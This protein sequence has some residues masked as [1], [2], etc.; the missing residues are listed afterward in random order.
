MVNGSVKF[1]VFFPVSREFAGEKF[2]LDW[3]LRHRTHCLGSVAWDEREVAA[4]YRDE[5][6]GRLGRE[7]LG[8]NRNRCEW[9]FSSTASS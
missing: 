9:S 3:I 2:A 5:I 6:A 8:I 1:P 7:I 4:C